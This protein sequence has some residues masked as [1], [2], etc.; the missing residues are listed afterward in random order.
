MAG[1]FQFIKEMNAKVKRKS[2]TFI[3][4]LAISTAL[5]LLIKLSQE[6]TTQSS[7]TLQIEDVTCDKWIST[8]T[9]NV[10]FAFETDG[11]ITLAH[12]LIREQKRTV[13]IS[14]NE[15]PYRLESDITYSFSS[16]Y[17]AERLAER[18]GIDVTDITM[19]DATVYFN[20]ENLKSKTVPVTLNDDL[21]LQR[22]Y[23]RYG[24]PIIT[25]ASVTVY[26][27]EETLSKI[28]CIETQPLIKE[29][30]SQSFTEKVPLN[31]LDGNI[32]CN[33]DE[34]EVSID[35]E[36]YTEIDLEVPIQPV[37]S[38][39]IR[40]IPASVQ[41]K[42]L[43]AIKDYAKTNAEAFS[44]VPDSADLAN[45]NPLLHVSLQSP[46]NLQVLGFMPERVEYI[47]ISHEK[48]W[49]NR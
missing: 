2:L 23:D 20:M 21:R 48:D 33:V 11:F 38:L 30:L 22:Q 36:K 40:F 41:V 6:Y 24:L 46:G 47:I 19:N 13:S 8:P 9:Q 1:S 5:W 28:H 39:E 43:V 14:L 49:N 27:T 12:N 29:N 32:R 17:V 10:K 15:V 4:F 45:R 18:L 25:P 42:C 34:V 35:I 16:N 26:G 7:F 31:L 37:D 3:V 44:A